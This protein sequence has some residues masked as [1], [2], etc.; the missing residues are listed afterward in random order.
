M[1]PDLGAAQVRVTL[2]LSAKEYE[3]LLAL[4]QEWR[5]T[6]RPDQGYAGVSGMIR[7]AIAHYLACPDGAAKDVATHKE[8]LQRFVQAWAKLADRRPG[9]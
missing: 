3:A 2:R 8:L 9:R 7:R 4:A 1:G 5:A 6:A